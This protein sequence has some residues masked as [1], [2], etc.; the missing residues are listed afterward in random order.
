MLK[1]SYIHLPFG[2]SM[3]PAQCDE[4]FGGLN[5]SPI[6][7]NNTDETRK[8]AIDHMISF[9]DLSYE[10]CFQKYGLNYFS[11]ETYYD[12]PDRIEGY[13]D[14]FAFDCLHPNEKGYAEIYGKNAIRALEEHLKA[15]PGTMARI[16]ASQG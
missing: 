10:S 12:N 5:N 9:V 2:L 14:L 6:F 4:F 3:T 13:T 7:K 15:E 16:S 8:R 11:I 1:Q